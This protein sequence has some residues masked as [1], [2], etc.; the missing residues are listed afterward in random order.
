MAEQTGS[1][2]ELGPAGVGDEA[3][4]AMEAPPSKSARKREMSALQALGESLC[5]LSAKELATIPIADENLLLTIKEAQGI[6]SN[7]ALRRHRQFIGKLM[8]HIDPEPIQRALDDLY[9]SRQQNTDAFH[10]LEAL[11][12]RLCEEGDQAM[13]TVLERYPLVDRQQLRQ[14]V[15][16]ASRET[17]LIKKNQVLGKPGSPAGPKASRRLFRFLKQLQEESA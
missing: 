5:A 1:D 13:S 7:S 14:L 11:R 9:S 8:R 16:D 6:R 17:T 3:M 4:E 15:R 10:A 12:D 2:E